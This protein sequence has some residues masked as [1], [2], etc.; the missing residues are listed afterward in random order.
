MAQLKA[1]SENVIGKLDTWVGELP[2]AGTVPIPA[3][4]VDA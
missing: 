1:L 4:R 3:R 2:E